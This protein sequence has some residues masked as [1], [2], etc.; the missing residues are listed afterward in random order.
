MPFASAFDARWEEVLQPAVQNVTHEGRTLEPFRVDMRNISDSVLTE[1]LDGISSAC[2]V[3]AD[4]TTIGHLGDIAIRN[5]NVM[6]EVG[7]AHASRLPEE[8]LLFRS[9]NDPLAFDVANV[10][11]N[12]YDPDSDP[13][14]TRTQVTEAIVD[15]LR[16]IDLAR[17]H[18]VRRVAD[19]IDLVALTVLGGAATPNGLAHP[20]LRTMGQV[21]GNVQRY[22]AITRLLDVGAI[23][24]TYPR[25]RAADIQNTPD[26]SFTAVYRVTPFGQ[27]ILKFLSEQQFGDNPELIQL[28]EQMFRDRESEDQTRG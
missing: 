10:R 4:I 26:R 24:T 13:G 2:L 22:Q 28:A 17:H 25:I 5:G 9:D 14:G 18:A 3:M 23:Q 21:L 7:V 11:V 27:A 15:S 8:V 6:Y 16:E 19:G 12:R 1:I 20:E